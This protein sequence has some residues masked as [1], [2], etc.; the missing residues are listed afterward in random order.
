MIRCVSF[1]INSRLTNAR[2]FLPRLFSSSI[3]FLIGSFGSGSQIYMSWLSL[4]GVTNA[5]RNRHVHVLVRQIIC[6]LFSPRAFLKRLKVVENRVRVRFCLLSWI[7]FFRFYVV[8]FPLFY[9]TVSCPCRQNN[10]GIHATGSRDTG[11]FFPVSEH[12]RQPGLPVFTSRRHARAGRDVYV[13][14][15]SCPFSQASLLLVVKSGLC[16]KT[17]SHTRSVALQPSRLG[18]RLLFFLVSMF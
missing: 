2:M 3:N 1:G 6:R 18:N 12:S 11:R 8:A 14:P 7:F 4:E 16:R 13:C 15:A 9:H 5:H 17:F 10:G